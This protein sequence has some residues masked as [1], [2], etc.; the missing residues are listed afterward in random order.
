MGPDVRDIKV[1]TCP[2]CGACLPEIAGPTH[3][4]MT[5]SAACFEAFTDVLAFEYSDSALLPTHR[6]TVD[7]F[8]VQHGGGGETRRQVQ[9]TG[10]HLAR[11]YLQLG[12]NLTPQDSNNVMLGLGQHKA[13]L[14]YLAPPQSYTMTV[15]DVRPFAGGPQHATKVREWAKATWADW[16]DHHAY[17]QDWTERHLR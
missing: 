9:S 16:Q 14:I 11:L 6:L 7:T 17:I 10:L 5:S 4:Y 15:S 3:S 2:G 13:S 1:S 8:A 12:R